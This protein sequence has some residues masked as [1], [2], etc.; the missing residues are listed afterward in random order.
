MNLS[1]TAAR[2]SRGVFGRHQVRMDAVG[3]RGPE[4]EHLGSER[5]DDPRVALLPS[6]AIIGAA[7]M[8]V[9]Y[10]RMAATGVAYS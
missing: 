4:L 6:G 2:A 9:R 5:R 8:A 7:S 1:P 3:E 10:S